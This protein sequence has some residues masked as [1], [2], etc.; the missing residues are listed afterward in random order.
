[1]IPVSHA[2]LVLYAY[3]PSLLCLPS[4]AKIAAKTDLKGPIYFLSFSLL[5]PYNDHWS[6]YGNNRLKDG[7]YKTDFL[8][9]SLELFFAV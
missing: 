5:P 9:P 7:K 2:Y 3:L 1:M 4:T 6:L 8:G